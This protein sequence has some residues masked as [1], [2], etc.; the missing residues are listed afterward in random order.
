MSSA[1]AFNILDLAVPAVANR[2]TQQEG[3]CRAELFMLRPESPCNVIYTL[4][5]AACQ[6]EL[7]F[8]CRKYSPQ[9][10]RLILVQSK[11]HY[12]DSCKICFI[13]TIQQQTRSEM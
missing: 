12:V 13:H 7:R 11:V 9:A 2:A 6:F 5:T 8:I 1:N 3:F 4:E 10:L